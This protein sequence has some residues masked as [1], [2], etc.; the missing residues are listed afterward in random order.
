ME[1][2]EKLTQMKVDFEDIDDGIK[3]SKKLVNQIV[4]R[5]MRDRCIRALL[6]LVLIG[7]L[8]VII[9]SLVDKKSS[10]DDN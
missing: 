3:Q 1:D 2:R 5:L 4:R 9:W 6:I 10:A 7:V 8:A